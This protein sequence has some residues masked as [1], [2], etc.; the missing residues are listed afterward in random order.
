MLNR[1]VA[2]RRAHIGGYMGKWIPAWEAMMKI[3]K[4]EFLSDSPDPSDA[5]RKKILDALTSGQLRA[6]ARYII[7]ECDDGHAPDYHVQTAKDVKLIRHGDR[8]QSEFAIFDT[9]LPLDF[10]SAQG[11]W[12]LKPVVWELGRFQAVKTTATKSGV[13]G[14]APSV[15]TR[16]Y[17]D[18]LAFHQENLNALIALVEAQT[19][20]QQAAF[21]GKKKGGAPLGRKYKADDW[22]KF[23]VL[24][25]RL[26]KEGKLER[27]LLESQETILHIV[28]AEIGHKIFGDT[29]LRRALSAVWNQVLISDEASQAG[30]QLS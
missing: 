22:L 8:Q 14:A 4:S 18:G 7:Q 10:F 13:K 24:I 28:Q 26:F 3:R 16:R 23:W 5:A 6:C 15:A 1:P 27:S 19:I 11:G 20:A 30:H 25:L 29:T 21:D 2:K 12:Q 9:T 17:V